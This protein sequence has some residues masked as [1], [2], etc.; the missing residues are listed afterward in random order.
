MSGCFQQIAMNVGSFHSPRPR[1]KL[2][3]ASLNAG[4]EGDASEEY[5]DAQSQE[6][7]AIVTTIGGVSDQTNLLALNAA[8]VRASEQGRGSAVAADKV[9]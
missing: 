3:G 5:L 4:P 2:I 9:R 7:G 1:G 8:I 6:I